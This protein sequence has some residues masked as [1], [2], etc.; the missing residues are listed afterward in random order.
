MR[1]KVV[2]VVGL[3]VSVGLLVAASRTLASHHEGPIPALPISLAW[4]GAGGVAITL[5]A[6]WLLVVDTP[7]EVARGTVVLAGILALLAIGEG[8]IYV[9][10]HPAYGMCV[11]H[12]Q[13]RAICYQQPNRP[14]A[15]RHA[16]ELFL[17]GG[18]AVAAMGATALVALR[19]SRP[20]KA[21]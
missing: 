15:A 3:A 14:E 16:A 9:D 2:L 10:R 11:R 4:L 20:A 17:A 6:A 1:W 21:A 19:R 18:A 12:G 13:G 5:A 7:I 8:A